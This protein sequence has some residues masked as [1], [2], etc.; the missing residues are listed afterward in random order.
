MSNNQVV[1][2]PVPVDGNAEYKEGTLQDPVTNADE[3]GAYESS[4]GINAPGDNVDPES[5]KGN[6]ISQSK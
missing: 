2:D 1:R 3:L 4:K 5:V 6:E